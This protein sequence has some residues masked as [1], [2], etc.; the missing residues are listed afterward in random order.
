[1]ITWCRMWSEDPALAHDVMTD[2]CVQWSGQTAGLDSVVGPAEQEKFVTAYR[3]QHVN[4]FTPRVVVDGGGQLAYLWDVRLPDGTV[5]TG[6]DVNILRDGKVTE[7]WTF[8]SGQHCDLPDPEAAPS[9]T[10]VIERLCRQWLEFWNG[11]DVPGADSFYPA[12]RWSDRGTRTVA[13]HRE[14]VIDATRGRAALLRTE[15]APDGTDSSA[16][17][18][19]SIRDGRIAQAW[20][21]IGSR[22]F[23]Y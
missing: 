5:H 20:S 18:L 19:L 1:M 17:D 4:V 22:A 15:T 10:A 14:P 6:A 8:V 9:D 21:L 11:A 13:V 12:D 16:V 2:D 23:R 3:A 7:N